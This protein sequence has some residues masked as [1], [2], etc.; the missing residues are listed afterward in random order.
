MATFTDDEN[1][2][3]EEFRILENLFEEL[4]INF[5]AENDYFNIKSYGMSD[6]YITAIEEGSNMIRVGSRIFGTRNY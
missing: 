6:D 1:Q 2:I 5:F 4:R 3:R